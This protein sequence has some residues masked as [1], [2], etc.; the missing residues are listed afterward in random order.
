MNAYSQASDLTGMEGMTM[1]ACGC[2][3]TTTSVGRA[4][5]NQSRFLDLHNLPKPRWRD[6][7]KALA[8]PAT[9]VHRYR[10]LRSAIFYDAIDDVDCRKRV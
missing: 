1:K 7:V 9:R 10:N 2:E 4:L 8:S 6:A 3:A 5:K